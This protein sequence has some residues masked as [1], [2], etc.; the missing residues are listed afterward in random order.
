[1]CCV[2]GGEVVVVGDFE[3]DA[4]FFEAFEEEGGG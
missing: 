1:L 2:L 3:G 4:V